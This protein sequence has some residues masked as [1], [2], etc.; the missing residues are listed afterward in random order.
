MKCPYNNIT[1][2]NLYKC[3]N[4][5]NTWYVL[6]KEICGDASIYQ[7]KIQVFGGGTINGKMIIPT[8]IK[9]VH[10]VQLN[11]KDV[12]DSTYTDFV[13]ENEIL[14]SDNCNLRKEIHGLKSKMDKQWWKFWKRW[15]SRKDITGK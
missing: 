2:L 13:K 8:E 1:T 14:Y 12:I 10:R 5:T 7:E 11:I 15:G 6:A 4:D 9:L 3:I